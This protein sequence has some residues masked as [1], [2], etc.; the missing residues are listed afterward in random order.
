MEAGELKS[1]AS[2]FSGTR[3]F[4]GDFNGGPDTGEALAMSESYSDAWT[5]AMNRGTA[6][7]YPDNP[8][9][10]HTRTRRGRIDYVFYSSNSVLFANAARIPDSRDLNNQNVVIRLGTLDDKGVRPSDHNAVIADFDLNVD[11]GTPAPTPTPTPTPTPAPTPATPPILLTDIITNRGLAL[12][13][14][15]LVR[16]PF[17]ITSPLNPGS[18]KRTRIT[19][20]STNVK[21]FSGE[22]ASAITAKAVSSFGGVYQLPVEYAAKV[23]GYDWLWHVMVRLPEDPSLQGNIS[24]TISLHGVSS[25]S[26]TLKIA[27]PP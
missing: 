18:D 17:W 15:L 13:S 5:D 23:P 14:T 25:N 19:L 7:A 11:T 6:S 4:T 2:G 21:L 20:F 24:V 9:G 26:V 8:V 12:H 27:P 1:F 16:D 10:M 3:I 22:T